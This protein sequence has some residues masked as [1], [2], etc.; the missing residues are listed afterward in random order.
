METAR[1]PSTYGYLCNPYVVV[2]TM[3]VHTTPYRFFF[4][5]SP[6][7]PEKAYGDSR[8]EKSRLNLFD[9]RLALSIPYPCP[10]MPGQ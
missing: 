8:S 5:F 9:R 4:V 7:S 3:Y 10:V 2:C 1:L 6:F